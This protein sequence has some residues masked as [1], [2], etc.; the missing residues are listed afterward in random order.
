MTTLLALTWIERK[1]LGRIQMRMGPMRTGIYGL[2]QPIAD[3]VKLLLKEDLMPAGA[4]RWLY[5]MAPYIAFIPAV[6]AWVSIPFSR[7]LVV[8]HMDLGLFYIIAVSLLSIVGMVIAGWA[9]ANKYALLGAA[10]AAAQM[11]S[12][13]L[14]L[15]LAM[16]GAAMYAQS[17][18][19]REVVEAQEHYPLFLL[20]PL[21]LFLFILAGLA[22][23]GRTPFDIPHAESELIG[24]PYIEYSGLRWSFFTGAEYIHTF[25]LAAL[26]SLLFLGGW[27]GPWLPSVLWFLAKTY[28]VILFIFWL[29]ATFPRLR[30]DQLMTF[31]WR[32]L[33]PL[34]FANVVLIGAGLYYKWPSWVQFLL[35][36]GLVVL[37]SRLIYRGQRRLA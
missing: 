37:A 5:K 7:N 1:F 8:R 17:L 25:A 29:R 16:L 3:T 10:R 18:N 4:D 21:G 19:L 33:L 12:Y 22:E 35:S 34:A 2:L 24:G 31:V 11:V 26:T 20:Q 13:E 28:A 32:L 14:P 27:N 9:S 36:L 23:V 15:V 30:I 6:M